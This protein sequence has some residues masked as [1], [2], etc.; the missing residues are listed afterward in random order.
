MPM[1]ELRI[2]KTCLVAQ[3]AALEVI[4]QNI[5]NAST[6]CYTRQRPVMEAIAATRMV[7]PTRAGQ[8]VRLKYVQRLWD[9]RLA[10]QM[11]YQRGLHKYYETLAHGLERVEGVVGDME[12]GLAKALSEFFNAW[13]QLGADGSNV[14]ARKGVVA[15]AQALADA[16][17]LQREGLQTLHTDIEGQIND[18]VERANG[19]LA[20]VAELNGQVMGNE[21]R[22]GG[23]TAAVQ[24]DQAC[25]ELAELLGATTVVQP[26]G[27]V[28]VLVGGLHVVDG[29]RAA[30]IEAVP[31][32][33][34]PTIHNI[35]IQGHVNPDGMAGQA[36]GLI[37][38]RDHYIP[39]YLARLD[40]LAQVLADAVNAQHQLGFDL[41]GNSGDVFFVYDPAGAAGTLRVS[42]AII[43]DISLI[44][45]SGVNQAS[46]DGS[47]AF[48]IGAIRYH[49]L[50]GITTAE[51]YAADMMAEVG[52]DV[53]WAQQAALTRQNVVETLEDQYQGL[54]GVS[55]DEEA[56]E[57]MKY[58]KAFIASARVAQIVNEMMQSV[59]ELV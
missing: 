37:Q 58:Q 29:V 44:A 27:S 10:A 48:A 13:D 57:L 8:G 17:R 23:N 35:S 20:R 41:N 36:L 51:Q 45:A 28:L 38:T 34:D 33:V 46:A 53:E 3:R 39:A 43:A 25:Q 12:K 47:N 16:L 24:R 14:G 49:Q 9:A 5:A 19:L 54:Y 4:A 40:E 30:T 22:M 26:D 32:A 11:N 1:G 42:D 21:G 7:D 55:V 56:V 52:A 6:P 59:L 50:L 31:D 2:V 18:V 15:A